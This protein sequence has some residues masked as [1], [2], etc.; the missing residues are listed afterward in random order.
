MDNVKTLKKK[1]TVRNGKIE[2][3]RF[4]F[5]L[6]I[7]CY[8]LGCSVKFPEELFQRGYLAVEFYF[9]VSGYLFARSLS[10]YTPV[11]HREL[12]SISLRYMGKKYLNFYY[13]YLI[14][15]LMTAAAWIPFFSAFFQGLDFKDNRSSAYLSAAADVRIPHG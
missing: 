10:K 14:V 11:E 15:I 3:L 5:A 1:Q 8:H 12:L 13:D 7:A 9:V 6:F 4:V 2:L